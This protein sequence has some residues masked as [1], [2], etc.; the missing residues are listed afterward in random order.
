MILEETG[1]NTGSSVTTK[2]G[3]CIVHVISASEDKV[4]LSVTVGSAAPQVFN[5]A[6]IGKRIVVRVAAESYYVDLLRV[7]GG[8]VDLAISKHS[9]S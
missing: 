8:I 1:V 2:D 3:G 7:R 5:G 6:L 4:S 9:G